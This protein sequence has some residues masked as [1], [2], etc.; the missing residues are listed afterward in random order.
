LAFPGQ[1]S[2]EQTPLLNGAAGNRRQPFKLLSSGP[3]R[4]PRAGIFKIPGSMQSPP[5]G[6]TSREAIGIALE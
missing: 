3:V 6:R 1:N 5:S 2:V 4:R